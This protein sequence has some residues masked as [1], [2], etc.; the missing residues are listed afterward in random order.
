[1]T[2]GAAFKVCKKAEDYGCSNGQINT[3]MEDHRHYFEIRVPS[4]CADLLN[5]TSVADF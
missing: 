3:S 5:A 1:M 2:A 4:Y